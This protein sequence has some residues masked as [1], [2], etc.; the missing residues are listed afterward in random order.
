[1]DKPGDQVVKLH[2]KEREKLAVC[3]HGIRLGSVSLA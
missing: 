3:T 2:V 1:M